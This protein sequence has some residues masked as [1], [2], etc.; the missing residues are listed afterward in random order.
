MS[1]GGVAAATAG[2]ETESERS[3][4]RLAPH[5]AR[6][7]NKHRELQRSWRW[8]LFRIEMLDFDSALQYSN[9]M[10]ETSREL[11]DAATLAVDVMTDHHCHDA[12]AVTQHNARFLGLHLTGLRGMPAWQQWAVMG[13]VLCVLV[14]V[15]RRMLCTGGRN[16]AKIN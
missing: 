15:V 6:V 5:L 11:W 10:L 12:A 7:V 8:L 16:K 2:G 9:R 13:A 3:W 4:S 14:Y 1:A